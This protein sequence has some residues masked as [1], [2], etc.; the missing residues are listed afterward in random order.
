MSFQDEMRTAY[1]MSHTP[2]ALEARQVPGDHDYSAAGQSLDLLKGQIRN[3][4]R[5]NPP[6]CFTARGSVLLGGPQAP[7]GYQQPSDFLLLDGISS[8]SPFRQSLTVYLT[9]RGYVFLQDL[10]ALAEE[11]G[12]SLSYCLEYQGRQFPLP[13]EARTLQTGHQLP[14]INR[15]TETRPKI[16]V[17]YTF[18]VA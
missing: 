3:Q 6:N 8:T 15:L 7:K 9:K 17:F 5:R 2:A 16:R 11:A 10:Q 13:V 4:L 1:H 18:Q 14:H 12:I